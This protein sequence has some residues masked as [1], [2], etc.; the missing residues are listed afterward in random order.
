MIIVIQGGSGSGKSA[1]A[2]ERALSLGGPLYYLATMKIY[3]EE[4]KRKAERHRRL[5][6]GKGFQTIEQPVKIEEAAELID[7]GSTVLLECMSNLTANEM[8][9][10]EERRDGQEAAA[11]ILRGIEAA[12]GKAEHL[13]IVSD[14]VFEDGIAYDKS[15]MEYMRA[16]GYVNAYMAE[17]AEEVT[18]VVAGIPLRI[19]GK[20]GDSG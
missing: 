7:Q 9:A 15:T 11:A 1:Y 6:A 14:N 5:R 19:K 12:A 10:E 17:L 4:G 2:E 16:L 13:I 18:E 3:D 8:F 20:G